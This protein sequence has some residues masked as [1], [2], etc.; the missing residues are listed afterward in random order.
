MS[1][2]HGAWMGEAACLRCRC[3]CDSLA[4]LVFE[5]YTVLKDC[6]QFQ[7]AEKV[8]QW[9]YPE[10]TTSSCFSVWLPWKCHTEL[11]WVGGVDWPN[12]PLCVKDSIYSGVLE[13]KLYVDPFFVYV[14]LL[15]E[16][17]A[18]CMLMLGKCSATGPHPNPQIR[19]LWSRMRPA[20]SWRYGAG[21]G[22]CS[23]WHC[24]LHNHWLCPPTNYLPL[25]PGSLEGRLV[26]HQQQ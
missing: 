20:C 13:E 1:V 15:V 9:K 2:P 7:G 21:G 16:P 23:L 26:I 4:S 18:L 12:K 17:R 10:F 6:G 3:Y 22:L 19:T 5:Y 8:S 14:V 11:P 24:P 25:V